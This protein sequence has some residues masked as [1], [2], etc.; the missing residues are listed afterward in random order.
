MTPVPGHLQCYQSWTTGAEPESASSLQFSASMA[1]YSGCCRDMESPLPDICTWNSRKCLENRSSSCQHNVQCMTST[2][3]SAAVLSQTGAYHLLLLSHPVRQLLEVLFRPVLPRLVETPV[4]KV[5]HLVTA[6]LLLVDSA[7]Q[8]CCNEVPEFIIAHVA[9]GKA[10]D[11]EV[12]WHHALIEYG[13]ECWEDFL[14]S[15]IS[16]MSHQ[17]CFCQCTSA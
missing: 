4:Q 14:L 5:V 3:V 17:A 6:V 1:H 2:I 16:C 10:I 11:V 15:K 13:K 9:P 12:L 8:G 7:G